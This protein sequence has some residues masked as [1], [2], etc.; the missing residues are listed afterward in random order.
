MVLLPEQS[1]FHL[2]IGPLKA[3]DFEACRGM[4]M[5]ERLGQYRI[6]HF[7]TLYVRRVAAPSGEFVGGVR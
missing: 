5:S 3:L 2:F 7:A 6:V 4:A 1:S